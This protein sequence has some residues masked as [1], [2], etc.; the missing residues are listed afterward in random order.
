MRARDLVE[1]GLNCSQSVFKAVCENCGIK[2]DDNMLSMLNGISAGFGIDGFCSAVIGTLC[3]LG[4]VYDED[5]MKKIRLLLLMDFNERFSGLEC[6]KISEKSRDCGEVMNF[7]Q[8]WAEAK[9][10]EAKK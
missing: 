6:G 8:K 10:K 4:C 9:I 1:E 3:A 2:T 7:L 5:E